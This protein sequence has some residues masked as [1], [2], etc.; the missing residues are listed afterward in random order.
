M[1]ENQTVAEVPAEMRAL[2][3]DGT[4]FEHLRTRRVPTPRPG[5]AQ[6]LARVDAAGI[7]TS[8]LKLVG[9]GKRSRDL[10][11]RLSKLGIKLNKLNQALLGP[12]SRKRVKGLR[13]KTMLELFVEIF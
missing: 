10:H 2:V 8:L 11:S 4:G 6:M 12:M 7:C 3:L 1:A 5:P 9:Q 13:K